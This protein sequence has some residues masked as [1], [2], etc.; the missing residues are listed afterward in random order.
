MWSKTRGRFD[1]QH[2][3]RIGAMNRDH[4]TRFWNALAERSDDG[5][6]EWSEER[7]QFESG[8]ALR[9]PP[10]STTI[11][12]FGPTARSAVPSLINLL[13]ASDVVVRRSAALAPWKNRAGRQIS[14]AFTG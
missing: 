4:C 3:T 1:L 7:R 12:D 14:R 2:R 6:L 9:L 5:A 13:N 11:G 10:H 8:V